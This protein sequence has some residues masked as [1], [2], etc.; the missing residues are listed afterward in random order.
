MSLRAGG[1]TGVEHV[2]W[3]TQAP[4]HVE[5]FGKQFE[6]EGLGVEWLD[7]G[8]VR[9]VGESVLVQAPGGHPFLFYYDVE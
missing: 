5:A 6:A 3:R 4:E 7:P 2:A 9:S 8:A 1:E